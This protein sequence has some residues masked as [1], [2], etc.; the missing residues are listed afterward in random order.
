MGWA[1]I[2]KKKSL[3]IALKSPFFPPAAGRKVYYFG[4]TI[5]QNGKI[6]MGSDF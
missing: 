6:G 4:L 1:Q 3:T 2:S 5:D